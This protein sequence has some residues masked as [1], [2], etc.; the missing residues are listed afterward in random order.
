MLEFLLVNGVMTSF[1]TMGLDQ[2]FSMLTART[3]RTAAISAHSQAVL[4]WQER[5]AGRLVVLLLA[6][7]LLD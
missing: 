1:W 3:A 5:G 6:D 7:W 4:I 2:S